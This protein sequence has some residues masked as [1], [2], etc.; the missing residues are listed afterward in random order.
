MHCDWSIARLA[1]NTE[2][3]SNKINEISSCCGTFLLGPMS[4]VKMS[5]GPRLLG[6]EKKRKKE[7]RKNIGENKNQKRI[8][9]IL[10]E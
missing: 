2:N 6:L 8:K 9:G 10:E 5:D 7:K 3:L 4:I 1:L